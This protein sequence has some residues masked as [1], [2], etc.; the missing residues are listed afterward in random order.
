VSTPAYELARFLEEQGVGI[1]GGNSDWSLHVGREPSDPDNVTTLY[2]TGG[3]EPLAVDPYIGQPQVQV[4]V[5]AHGTRYLEAYELQERIRGLL[6]QP[7]A[8]LVPGA[9]E[10]TIGVHRYVQ[11]FPIADI[12]AIGRDDKDRHIVVANYQL[13]RQAVENAS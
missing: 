5:R 7:G 3:I 11:I 13:I 8:G 4:R 2:D 6:V 12:L 9:L 10:R 1:W